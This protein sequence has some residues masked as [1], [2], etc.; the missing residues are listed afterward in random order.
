MNNPNFGR[1]SKASHGLRLW[2]VFF[3]KKDKPALSLTFSLSL[4]F[5]ANPDVGR[6]A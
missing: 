3:P 2:F 4:T 1:L 5:L 6:S